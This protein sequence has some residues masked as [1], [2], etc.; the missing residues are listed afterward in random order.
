MGN[1][2]Q[3]RDSRGRWTKGAGAITIAAAAVVGVM[4]VGGGAGAGGAASVDSALGQTVRANVSKSKDP[5]RKGKRDDAW[6]G[7]GLKRVREVSKTRGVLRA[8]FL[9]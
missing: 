9:R 2:H 7:M 4:S 6:R 5:A 8:A 3:P 1:P